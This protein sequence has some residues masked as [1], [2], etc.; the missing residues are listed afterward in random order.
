MVFHLKSKNPCDFWIPVGKPKKLGKP[1]NPK[2]SSPS[3]RFWILGFLHNW[4]PP[5][6]L[7]NQK[8]KIQNLS[9]GPQTFRFFGFPRVFLVFHQKSQKKHMVFFGFPTEIQKTQ[10]VFAFSPETEQKNKQTVFFWF[11]FKIKKHYVLDFCWKAKKTLGR[12]NKNKSFG[13]LRKVL[14]FW[15]FFWFLPS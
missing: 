10:G 2:V 7:Q 13:P 14:G 1:Q 9:E 11:P 3:E 8:S 15:S 5:K 12:P 4:F 6:A